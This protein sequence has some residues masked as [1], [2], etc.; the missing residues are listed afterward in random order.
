MQRETDVGDKEYTP[1]ERI[2]GQQRSP[3]KRVLRSAS[4]PGKASLKRRHRSRDLREATEG[5]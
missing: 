2:S 1:K 4:T 3:A 5:R